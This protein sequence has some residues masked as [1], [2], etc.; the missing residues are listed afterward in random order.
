MPLAWLALALL[1][2][3]R[4]EPDPRDCAER[5]T[6]YPDAD[7]NG[8]GEPTRVYV[9]CEAPEGW[10]KELDPDAGSDTGL[11]GTGTP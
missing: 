10:V 8:L 1:S 2:C 4:D 7:G 5:A 9:G 3:V 11:T 6:Y